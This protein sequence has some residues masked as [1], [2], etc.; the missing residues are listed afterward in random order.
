MPAVA[1]ASL[2]GAAACGVL[3]GAD[4]YPAREFGLIVAAGLVLD[5]ILRPPLIAV[6]A[7]WAPSG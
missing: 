2:V 3:A 7:R 5:L 4:L 6:L 1:A